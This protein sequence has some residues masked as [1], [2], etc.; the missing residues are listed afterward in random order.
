MVINPVFFSVHS[1]LDLHWI[2]LNFVTIFAV[3]IGET[4][5]IQENKKT[6]AHDGVRVIFFKGL[7]LF[8][9]VDYET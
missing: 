4:H 6:R 2:F 5:V 7:L 3:I 1:V 8:K 9:I